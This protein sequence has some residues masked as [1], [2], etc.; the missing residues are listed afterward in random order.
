MTT[1][2]GNSGSTYDIP[3]YPNHQD[4]FDRNDRGHQMAG[5][6][7]LMSGHEPQTFG[8]SDQTSGHLTGRPDAVTGHHDA[9]TGQPNE[10]GRDG[11][12]TSSEDRPPATDPGIAG[13]TSGP[14]SGPAGGVLASLAASPS[15]RQRRLQMLPLRGPGAVFTEPQGRT[16]GDATA[17]EN[18]A[19]LI[20]SISVVGLVQPVLVEQLGPDD[21]HSGLRLVSG[22]RR[23]RAMRWGATHD[24]QNP[25]FAAIPAVVCPGPLSDAERRCWQLVENI[26]REDLQPGELAAA[27]L[28]E[29]CAIVEQ[30][31]LAAGRTIP[32]EVTTAEDPMARW[33]GLEKLR[34]ANTSLAAPWGEVLH[35]LG[36]QLSERR[37]RQLV[38][39]FAALPPEISADM[40]AAKVRLHT[41]ITFTQLR[42]GREQAAD[43]I[44]AALRTRQR[45]DLLTA[46]THASLEQPDLST[47]EA[48]DLATQVHD[49]ANTARAEKLTKP[50]VDTDAD[51]TVREP[52]T[53]TPKLFSTVLTGLRALTRALRSGYASPTTYDTGSL[54]L[55]L[56]ELLS[57]LD[58]PESGRQQTD[59]V[60]EA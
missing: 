11:R 48:I 21:G 40:D 32:P 33:Q 31:L 57:L 16:P 34:G 3:G 10:A 59:R 55:Q 19:D 37:A 51:G 29:R 24:P 15:L 49:Q 13:P 20:S 5:Q 7:D 6:G 22:E 44:W 56:T 41:R 9:L 58:Q 17:P 8:H 27:L 12:S 46:A 1:Y 28:L 30:K 45:P 36:L 38:R 43:E 25:Q 4:D 42:A 39:A 26:A 54:K 60:G 18:L 35:R 53:E 14:G 47:D 50:A 2:P 23:L 52:R